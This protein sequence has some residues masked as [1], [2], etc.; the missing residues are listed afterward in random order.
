MGTPKAAAVSTARAETSIAEE[1]GAE[2]AAAIPTEAV[3]E[4]ATIP[5]PNANRRSIFVFMAQQSGVIVKKCPLC[6]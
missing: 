3:A 5:N 4:V 1:A 2:E 6:G